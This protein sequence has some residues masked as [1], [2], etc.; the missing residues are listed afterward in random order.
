MS[1]Q[2]G[3]VPP[4]SALARLR[5]G[6]RK[7]VRIDRNLHDRA[8]SGLQRRADDV[9]DLVRMLRVEARGTEQACKFVVSRIADVAADVAF[10]VESLLI[11]LLRA[12][13]IVV[14]DDRD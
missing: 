10:V 8:L 14:H 12:P 4:S 11:R 9:A 3:A 6:H 2:A 13:A 7:L 5:G 1:C